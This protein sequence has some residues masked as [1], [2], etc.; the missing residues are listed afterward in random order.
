MS[1]LPKKTTT[2]PFERTV[3]CDIAYFVVCEIQPTPVLYIAYYCFSF[4]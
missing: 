4:G 2:G 1:Y 3:V